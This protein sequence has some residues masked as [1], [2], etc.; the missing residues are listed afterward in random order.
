MLAA[1]HPLAVLFQTWLCSK[2]RWSLGWN[3]SCFSSSSVAGDRSVN[4]SLCLE[5]VTSCVPQIGSKIHQTS[6]RFCTLQAI[7]NWRQGRPENEAK[8]VTYIVLCAI[9]SAIVVTVPLPSTCWTLTRWTGYWKHTPFWRH[10]PEA[11]A[12]KVSEL[13]HDA[14]LYLC[15]W[16]RKH[17]TW[18]CTVIRVLWAEH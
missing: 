4:M 7:K 9:T 8:V 16:G 3:L 11:H 1:E 14:I 18:F 10:A 5:P 15:N 12:C 13:H 6:L 17:I 2:D